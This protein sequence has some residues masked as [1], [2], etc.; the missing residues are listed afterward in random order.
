MENINIIRNG[1]YDKDFDGIKWAVSAR[2]HDNLRPAINCVSVSFGLVVATDGHRLHAYTTDRNIPDG[3]YKIVS[4][5]KDAIIM[6][7]EERLTYPDYERAF[8]KRT[9]NGVPDFPTKNYGT[10]VSP[11][12]HDTFII[13]HI[14]KNS[15]GGFNIHHLM[16]ACPIGEELHFEQGVPEDRQP[17]VIRNQDYS[18]AALVMPLSPPLLFGREKP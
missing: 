8:P 5:T 3:V 4:Q 12:D 7:T 13:N 15:T 18:K 11:K 2:S 9:H 14:L 6:E 16:D 10:G 1:K 17:F